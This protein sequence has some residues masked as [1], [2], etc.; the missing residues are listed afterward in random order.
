[1]EEKGHLI[2][3]V[4]FIESYFL[5]NAEKLD[6]RWDKISCSCCDKKWPIKLT[7]LKKMQNN[8]QKWA[9]FEL[10]DL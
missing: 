10:K 2:L 7:I 6:N 4:D 3:P 1:M 9:R 8:A 5:G